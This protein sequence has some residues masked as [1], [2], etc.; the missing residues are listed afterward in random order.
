MTTPIPS[1]SAFPLR[2][3]DKLRYADT[4]RQGHVNN[5]VFATMLETGRV[6]FF[7]AKAGALHDAGCSFVIASL[8]IEFIDE[9]H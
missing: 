4:D 3:Q 9:M 8:Q 7:Y 2:A 1:L 5:A 6:E